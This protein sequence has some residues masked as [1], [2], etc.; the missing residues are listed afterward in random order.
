M[1]IPLNI[2]PWC[3]CIERGVFHRQD[4]YTCDH[5]SG[6]WVCS[7]CRKPSKMNWQRHT[8]QL[9]QIPQERR[10]LEVDIYEYELQY[11]MRKVAPKI[12]SQELAWD[13]DT[14]DDYDYAH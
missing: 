14:E 13:D 7:R 3:N 2:H 6:L 12:I 5:A 11:E 10:K 9:P 4:G 1:A 8:G